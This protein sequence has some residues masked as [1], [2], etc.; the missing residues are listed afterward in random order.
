MKP[1][2]G[3]V[4]LGVAACLAAACSGKPAQPSPA[5]DGGAGLARIRAAR[6]DLQ[7]A[8]EALDVLRDELGALGAGQR[9]TVGETSRKEELAA[10]VKLA[11]A[12]FEAA[13]SADQSALADFLN[14]ALNTQPKADSTIEALRLYS[15]S[16]LRNARDFVDHSGDYRR[17]IELLETARSYYDGVEAGAPDDLTSALANARAYRFVTKARFDQLKEGMTTSE[18]KALVGVPFCANIRH[19]EVGGRTVTTWLFGREDG[20]VAA[21]Y[22]DDRGKAYAWHWNVKDAA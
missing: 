21:I 7:R 1:L 9:L 19:S 2:A 13:Y 14:E 6:A 5:V 18:V 4:V 12:Q 8:W 20:E 15:D 3:M 17:A 16:A 22:L 11:E 10:K